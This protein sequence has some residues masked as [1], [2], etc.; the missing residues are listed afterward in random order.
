MLIFDFRSAGREP[1]PELSALAQAVQGIYG[2]ENV[3]LTGIGGFQSSVNPV[4]A[5]GR[6]QQTYGDDNEDE[7]SQNIAHSKWKRISSNSIVSLLI[8]NFL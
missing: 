3:I 8:S 6:L 5:L 1:V 4:H 2:E 7:N